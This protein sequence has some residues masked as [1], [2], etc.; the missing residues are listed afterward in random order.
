MFAG[1]LNSDIVK[2]SRNLAQ[3]MLIL[4]IIMATSITMYGAYTVH[5]VAGDVKLVTKGEKVR[6]KKGMTLHPSDVVE[7]TKGGLLEILND[8]DSKIYTCDKPGQLSVMRLMLDAKKSAGDNQGTI[9]GRISLG[10]SAGPGQTIFEEKGMVLRS[11]LIAGDEDRTTGLSAGKLSKRLHSLVENVPG[12]VGIAVVDDRDTVTL[13]NDV[14]FPMMSVFKLHQALAVADRLERSGNTLDSTIYI[15]ATDMDRDTWSPMMKKYGDDDFMI[16]VGELL[17]YA[18]IESDNNASN[19]LF[20][21]I[22]SPKETDRFVKTIAPDTT[23]CIAYSEAMMKDNHALCHSNYS[24]P[25]S[26]ATLLNK[27]FKS[28]VVSASLQDS[29]KTYLSEITTGTDRLAAGIDKKREVFFAH[30]TGSGYRNDNGELTAHND[31]GYFRM[32]DGRDYTVAVFIRDFKGSEDEA[33]H[34][35]AEISRI[36]SLCYNSGINYSVAGGLNDKQ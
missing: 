2:A 26:A 24:S 36:I 18:L 30:K 33:S 15:P 3:H 31:V 25:L 23:F 21:R 27:V 16:S 8:L 7:I 32:P 6:L 13:N 17:R 34:L 5:S 14:H 9:G 11:I 35:I 4:L 10:K 19:L 20:K 29:I 22:V 28:Q 1:N 12:T